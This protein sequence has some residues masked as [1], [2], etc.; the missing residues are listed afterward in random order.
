MSKCTIFTILN[1]YTTTGLSNDELISTKNSFLN[2]AS[3]KY[4]TPNQKIGF[5]NRILSNDLD[6]SY[7]DEQ[8]NILSSMTLGEINDIAS[9][10]IRKDELVIVVVGNKY[11]IKEKLE[12][13][14]SN[15]GKRFNFEVIDIK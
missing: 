15:E 12:S 6:A 7:I 1:D 4:E 8:S 9:N 10:E 2:S 13:L 11:L 3:M 5:L 14:S